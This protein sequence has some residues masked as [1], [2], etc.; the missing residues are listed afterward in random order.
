MKARRH[1]RTRSRL[2]SPVDRKEKRQGKKGK[3]QHRRRSRV[4]SIS[5]LSVGPSSDYRVSSWL[6]VRGR[7]ATPRES[8]RALAALRPW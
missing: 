2:K 7:H 5:H 6:G 4:C 3:N 1:N 8:E